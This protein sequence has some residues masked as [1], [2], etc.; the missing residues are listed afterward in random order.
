VS[1]LRSPSRSTTPPAN[2]HP[3][4][5]PEHQHTST[6]SPAETTSAWSSAF[7]L[8][9][10]ELQRNQ[11]IG[12]QGSRQATALS[13]PCW[14][15]ATRTTA[16]RCGGISALGR[17]WRGA[18]DRTVHR[19]VRGRGISVALA[20][21]LTFFHTYKFIMA[22][23]SPSHS[24]VRGHR[25]SSQFASPRLSSNARRSKS[26]LRGDLHSRPGPK[27]REAGA[28]HCKASQLLSTVY[29]TGCPACKKHRSKTLSQLKQNMQEPYF[30]VL[31]SQ[32][33]PLQQS[34]AT[35][36]KL[37]LSNFFAAQQRPDSPQHH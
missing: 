27:P 20:N 2:K 15:P 35:A 16:P 36:A 19:L 10:H 34:Q 24:E 9:G 5:S 4:A 7:A 17:I 1:Y 13:W 33:R 14:F 21:A 6:S 28:T 23:S 37:G 30:V 31:D 32:N 25:K 12:N 22:P 11:D 3:E 29:A 8:I 26:S 18:I